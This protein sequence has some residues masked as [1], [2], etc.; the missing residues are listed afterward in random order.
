MARRKKKVENVHITGIADKGKAVGRD[1]EG[2]VYFVE[3]AVPGDIVDVLVLRKK[4][5]FRQGI[6]TQFKH[7]SEDRVE[8]RCQH[9][10]VCGGCKWQNLDYQAQLKYKQKTVE[11]AMRKIGGLDKSLVLPILGSEKVYH[12]RNKVEYSFSDKRWITEEEVKS[13][14]PIDRSPAVGYHRPGAWDK[15]V[16]I[17]TCHLQDDLTDKIRNGV[18]QYAFENDLSF[19]NQQDHQGLLRNMIVRNSSLGEWMLIVAFGEKDEEAIE[20]MMEYLANQFPE[21]SSLQYVINLKKNDTLYDQD[22][23]V[24]KGKDHIVEQLGNAR[25]RIGPKS[26]FQ[27]NTAQAE[28]LYKV[29]KDF[30]QLNREDNVYDLYT[31]LGSIA[32][33]VADACKHVTGIEEVEAAIEDAQ[34]NKQLNHNENTTFY[35]G[36]VKDLLDDNFVE[37]HGKADVIITDPPRAGMHANVIDTLLKIAARRIV[38]V[39][40]NP[41]TQARDLQL[42][43][44]KYEVLKLQPVDM[45]PHTH[46][47]ENVALLEL[48]INE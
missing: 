48:K 9:F 1:S 43:S 26:F 34:L 33:Y 14:L 21:I 37:K 46:H 12:Y 16:D 36:D 27:T 24:Y 31:G 2:I 41:A 10:G 42:L 40:C 35:A 4:K 47:I 39:S 45:F 8:A 19:Y 30:A 18:R 44:K 29:T 11:D 20:G 5:S 25:Y 32:L 13:G 15:I 7:Y 3:G 28:V 6:V 22:I 17:N 38:Y 23:K